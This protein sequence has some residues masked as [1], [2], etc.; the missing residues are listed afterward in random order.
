MKI[1]YVRKYTYD[2][3]NY[4]SNEAGASLSASLIVSL[5]YVNRVSWRPLGLELK[6]FTKNFFI[7]FLFGSVKLKRNIFGRR[8]VSANSD[9]MESLRVERS[10]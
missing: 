10:R 5:Y 7:I 1:S 2:F 9:Q 6:L 8:S 4:H 3:F